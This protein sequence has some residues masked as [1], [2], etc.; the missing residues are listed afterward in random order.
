MNEIRQTDWATLERR[1][2]PVVGALTIL[3]GVVWIGIAVDPRPETN[4]APDFRPIGAIVGAATLVAGGLTVARRRGELVVT[5]LG[6]LAAAS[7]AIATAL[8]TRPETRWTVY[9]AS[10]V[11]GALLLGILV[12]RGGFE[13][14]PTSG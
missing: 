10:V 9:S 4:V 11:F 5:I 7:F 13:R 1:G 14:E 8:L 2:L 3:I 6:S 12:F